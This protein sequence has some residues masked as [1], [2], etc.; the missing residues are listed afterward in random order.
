M[1]DPFFEMYPQRKNV[2][3]VGIHPESCELL[4]SSHRSK[5]NKISQRIAAESSIAS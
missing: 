5:T 1:M 3:T 2:P 4:Q